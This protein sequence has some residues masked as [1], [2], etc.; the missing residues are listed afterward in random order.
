MRFLAV[1]TEPPEA[2]FKKLAQLELG[3]V[4]VAVAADPHH[5]LQLLASL[6]RQVHRQIIH[7]PVLVGQHKLLKRVDRQSGPASAARKTRSL[8]IVS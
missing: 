8:E 6:Q 4:N 2:G 3:D 1:E 5:L 7:R